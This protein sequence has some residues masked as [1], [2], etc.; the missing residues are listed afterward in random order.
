MSNTTKRSK[1][2]GQGMTEY[3]VLVGLVAVLLVGAVK[4]LA[5]SMGKAMEKTA[6]GV[7]KVAELIEAAGDDATPSV[8]SVGR[9]G[10]VRDEDEQLPDEERPG[11]LRTDQ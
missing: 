4:G 1:R 3:V 10:I 9:A 6:G 7:D 8:G 11:R 5:S 2:R